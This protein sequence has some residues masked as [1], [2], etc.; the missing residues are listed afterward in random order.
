MDV[1]NCTRCKKIFNYVGG[2]PVCAQCKKELEELFKET[3]LYIRR[4]PDASITEVSEKCN[5]DLKQIRQWIREE[6]LSFSKDSEIG[7]ECE[8]CGKS[9]R[10]GRFCDA[11]K[12][13]TLNE[14]NNIVRQ[15]SAP[16]ESVPKTENKNQM[17]FLNKEHGR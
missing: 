6:K 3:R 12:G 10:T 5:V 15:N 1:R 9:I 8:K 7:I 4:N 2:Q 13:D 16:I 17:R 14:L 11:C